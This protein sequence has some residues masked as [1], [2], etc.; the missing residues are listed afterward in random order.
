MEHQWTPS[1]WVVERRSR[2]TFGVQIFPIGTPHEPSHQLLAAGRLVEQLGLDAFYVSDHPAWGLEPWLHLGALAVVTERVRLGCIVHCAHYRHPVLTARLAA[3]LD[4]LSRGRLVLGLGAGWD[5]NEFANLGLSF[6]SARERQAA[7]EEAIAIIHGVWG[8]SPFSFDG[9]YFQTANTQVQPRPMQQPR[10]P[11]LIAGAGERVTLRQVAAHADACNFLGAV[12]FSGDDRVS[13]PD[14]VRRKLAALAAHCERIGRPADTILCTHLTGWL[15]LAP[16]PAAVEAKVRHY[17]PEGL[18]R[19]FTGAFANYVV[20]A[21]PAQAIE[22]YQA[23]A[24]AGVQHFVIASQDAADHE[25]LHLLSE[26]VMPYV[27]ST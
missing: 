12:A 2:I 15:M 6:L 20:A 11:L 8:D 22:H 14:D 26:E 21:T 4:N 5:A 25:T 23:L 19:R 16:T 3:D 18:E 10:P 17:V 24:E 7:L 13:G 1:P 9:R 27:Q